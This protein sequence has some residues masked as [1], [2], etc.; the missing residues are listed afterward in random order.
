MVQFHQLGAS[1]KLQKA[2]PFLLT[3][4]NVVNYKST[5][6]FE[7][8]ALG[9]VGEIEPRVQFQQLS[10]RHNFVKKKIDWDCKAIFVTTKKFCWIDS[11]SNK[12]IF[13]LF[14]MFD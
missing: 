11:W 8:K 7:V 3:L 12:R 4:Q 6:L 10:T 14:L 1:R 5:K 2:R 9:R 13:K